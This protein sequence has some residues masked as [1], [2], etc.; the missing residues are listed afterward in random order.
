MQ[1]ENKQVFCFVLCFNECDN[2]REMRVENSVREDSRY[3]VAPT[4]WKGMI[5][6]ETLQA[7]WSLELKAVIKGG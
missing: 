4:T 5:K 2:R 7:V 1:K 6:T 3:S